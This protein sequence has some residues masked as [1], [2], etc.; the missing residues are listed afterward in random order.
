MMDGRGPAIV[1]RLRGD[2]AAHLP[3]TSLDVRISKEYVDKIFT[4]HRLTYEDLDVVQFAL[5]NGWCIK[6]TAGKLDFL[7]V[8]ESERHRRF[9]VG[10]KTANGG[11]ET[12][13]QTLHL[14]DEEQIKRRLK[15]ARKHGT[16]IRTHTWE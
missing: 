1:A 4:K 16:L 14:T 15:Q 8:M 10:I 6:S 12:W 13:F 9:V 5:D 7:C 11:L 2:I 3:T